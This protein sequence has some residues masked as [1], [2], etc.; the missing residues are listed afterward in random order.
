MKNQ[1]VK[2]EIVSQLNELGFNKPRLVP[3]LED[4]WLSI[5]GDEYLMLSNIPF[6]GITY[7]QVIDWFLE[8]HKI[9][10]SFVTHEFGK[11]RFG[12]QMV[13]C[14]T[15]DFPRI[16]KSGDWDIEDYLTIEEAKEASIIK[17][18]EMLKNEGE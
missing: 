3:L 15:E 4:D 11:W 8:E 16:A 7:Q 12:T 17:A 9:F 14:P 2:D 1:I 6:K 5:G 18:I 10:I 13:D